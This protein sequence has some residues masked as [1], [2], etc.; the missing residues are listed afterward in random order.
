MSAFMTLDWRNDEQ[1]KTAAAFLTSL[2]FHLLLI[3]LVA[4]FF[5]LRPAPAPPVIEE[6]SVEL[7]IIDPPAEKPKAKP[8]Y[9]ETRE[10]QRADTP[11]ENMVFES[12][13]DSRAAALQ[14]AAGDAPLPTQDG[15]ESPALEF[16]NKEYTPGK[17]ASPSAPAVQPQPKESTPPEPPAEPVST[18]RQTTQLALLE[19]PKPTTTRRPQTKQPQPAV[20]P[21]PQQV[22]QPPGYQPQTRITRIRG[23]ISNRGRS[24]VDATATPLGRY[25]KMLSDAIGSRWYFYVN[26]QMGLL[27]MGTVDLHFVV[28]ASGKVQK[29][30]VMRNSSNES[31]ASCSVRAVMEAEIPP[32]PKELV[33]MLENG[34]I[35]IDYS[36]T[37]LSN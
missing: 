5:A 29:V 20:Q 4:I 8:A 30:E 35:E 34:R 6:E 17:L 33:P 9:I 15:V 12:D 21:Q 10:S 32:I 11:P 23:N 19:P 1:R 25:K 27:T 36:F 24:A 14:M 26:K 3:V 31:F 22:A 13:K 28:T 18:P 16:E 7:T 37:I 2:I